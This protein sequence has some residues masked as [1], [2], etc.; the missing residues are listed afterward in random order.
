VSR[1][2][3]R[4]NHIPRTP[5]MSNSSSSLDENEK[6]KEFGLVD[7]HAA[8]EKPTE[9]E[10]QED[11][12]YEPIR[13]EKGEKGIEA[14]GDGHG[15]RGALS[16][17]QSGASAFTDVSED[18]EAKSS[19][20]QRKW[21]RTNPLKWGPKPP[22]PKTREI[23]PEYNASLFSLLTWQWMQPL[24]NVGYKRPLEKND[25]YIVNPRR[26]ADVLAEKLEASFKKRLDDGYERPLL[27]AM[28]D[29]FVSFPKMH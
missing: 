12:R 26:S 16:R 8:V 21:Y 15:S 7:P 3:D 17:T 27:G 11:P 19:L 18:S 22:V 23:S 28:F 6:E 2:R 20:R 25:L 9:D 29:T 14:T 1:P 24:M 5:K 4:T 13:T 10:P